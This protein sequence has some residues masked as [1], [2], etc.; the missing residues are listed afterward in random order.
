MTGISVIRQLLL[1]LEEEEAAL[2]RSDVRAALELGERKADLLSRVREDKVP[3]EGELAAVKAIARR[4]ERLLALTLEACRQ[5]N[6]RVSQIE[7]AAARV[8]YGADGEGVL[9][10]DE[11][12]R[13][14]F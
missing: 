9:R 12:S 8:G 5:A 1:V 4:T 3:S 14:R 6:R 2:L 10:P 13:R 11:R 7:D